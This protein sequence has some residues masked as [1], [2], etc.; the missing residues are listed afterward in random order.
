MAC[1]DKSLIEHY[2]FMGEES[3]YR[4]KRTV[5]ERD[6]KPQEV[7]KFVE[8]YINVT[9]KMLR[10][11][12]KRGAKECRALCVFLVRYYCDYTYKQI[13]GLIGRL[14]LTRVSELAQIGHKLIKED[15]RYKNIMEDFIKYRAA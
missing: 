7:M 15:E 8:S 5:L 2:E 12:Y 11:K 3:E 4:C 6:F 13:C 10:W 1:N 9:E 14:T